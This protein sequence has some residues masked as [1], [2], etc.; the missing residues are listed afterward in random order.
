MSLDTFALFRPVQI[1]SENGF[2]L[3]QPHTAGIGVNATVDTGVY[4]MLPG[5]ASAFET[6]LV[7]LDSN[8]EVTFVVDSTDSDY[9]KI[10]IST[11]TDSFKISWTNGTE[12]RDALGFAG[13]ES[14]SST[15][16]SPYVLTG[17]NISKYSWW[18][19]Y[20]TADNKGWDLT[21]RDLYDGIKTR[22][23]RSVGFRTGDEVYERRLS[24]TGED[25]ERISRA[26]ATNSVESDGCL[27]W[28]VFKSLTEE[29]LIAD[30]PVVTGLYLWYKSSTVVPISDYDTREG[31]NELYTTDPDLFAFSSADLRGL[32]N[33][34]AQLPKSMIIYR[35]ELR[36]TKAEPPTWD[37]P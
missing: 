8:M 9:G 16:S 37:E 10:K 3:Y 24:I 6:S 21:V 1:V 35:A 31:I 28:F 34:S 27:E 30:S 22:N 5:L 32:S 11:T 13:T 25:A 23:G 17:D 19:L 12:L 15:A 2:A 7:A 26:R 20:G 33:I 18:S 4:G 36:I 29:P 14:T